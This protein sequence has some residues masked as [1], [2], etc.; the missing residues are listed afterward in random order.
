RHLKSESDGAGSRRRRPTGEARLAARYE[1]QHKHRRRCENQLSRLLDPPEKIQY[2]TDHSHYRRGTD[3]GSRGKARPRSSAED[4]N[5]RRLMT[6]CRI[7][8]TIVATQKNEH[9]RNKKILIAQPI[10][11]SGEPIGRDFLAIDS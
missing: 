3:H 11:T 6:L 2:R 1:R 4:S 7:T 10:S 8:G 5:D 9:L